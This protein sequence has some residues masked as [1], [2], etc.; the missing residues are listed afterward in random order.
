[1]PSL[2]NGILGSQDTL[3]NIDWGETTAIDL[4]ALNAKVSSSSSSIEVHF[5]K[6]AGIDHEISDEELVELAYWM[7]ETVKK[8][9]TSSSSSNTTNNSSSNATMLEDV[10][11]NL[12]SKSIYNC[13]FLV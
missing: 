3:I 4:L 1:M 10:T 12:K 8:V 6:F 7:K 9:S 13:H 11:Q 2:Y 5:R